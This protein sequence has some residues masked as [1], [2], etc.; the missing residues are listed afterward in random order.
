MSR[1]IPSSVIIFSF[2]LVEIQVLYSMELQSCHC[3]Y[4]VIALIMAVQ[5]HT[6]RETEGWEANNV[7]RTA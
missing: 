5:N 6:S 1:G 3:Y 4:F 7:F 2:L